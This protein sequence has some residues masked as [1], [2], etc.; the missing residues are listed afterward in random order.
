MGARFRRSATSSDRL[1]KKTRA[2]PRARS[3]L[4][5]LAKKILP[6]RPLGKQIVH[7]EDSVLGSDSRSPQPGLKTATYEKLIEEAFKP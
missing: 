5:R 7:P 6:L 3:S 2:L 1:I 4:G